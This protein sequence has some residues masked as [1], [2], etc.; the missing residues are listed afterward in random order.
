[1][2]TTLNRE[3]KATTCEHLGASATAADLE[4][5]RARLAATWPVGPDAELDD[6]IAREVTTAALEGR[7]LATVEVQVDEENNA[8]EWWDALRRLDRGSKRL[9][10]AIDSGR[11]TRAQLAVLRSLP[12]WE[13]G[14]E[15]ARTA[16]S[17]RR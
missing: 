17:V 1:M 12:G 6:D 4:A 2:P 8:E 7:E 3:L 11:V 16:L 14:P 9:E 13:D 15:F 10:R 5:Y